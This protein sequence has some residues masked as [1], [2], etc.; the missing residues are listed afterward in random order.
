M[1]IYVNYPN[2]NTIKI[3]KEEISK[4]LVKYPNNIKTL[5]CLFL[6]IWEPG[7]KGKEGVNI[8]KI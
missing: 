7:W 1:V 3:F 4:K 5:L 2:L 6:N 8:K